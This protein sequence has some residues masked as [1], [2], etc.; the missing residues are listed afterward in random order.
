VLAWARAGVPFDH[1]FDSATPDRLY[2]TEL[3]WRAYYSA[4]VELLPPGEAMHKRIL[5][6]DLLDGGGLQEVARF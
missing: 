1:D 6:A 4:G 2:C 5:P 3:V